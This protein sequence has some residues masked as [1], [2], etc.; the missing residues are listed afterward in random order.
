MGTAGHKEWVFSTRLIP[1]LSIDKDQMC[2]F[3]ILTGSKCHYFSKSVSSSAVSFQ[4]PS[5]K[6]KF[7][8]YVHSGV[9]VFPPECNCITH[10]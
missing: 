9:D 1:S 7:K 4:S 10:Q 6:N 8:G 5:G 3:W 2:A